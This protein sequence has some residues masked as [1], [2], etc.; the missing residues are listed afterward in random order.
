[1][2]KYRTLKGEAQRAREQGEKVT[3]DAELLLGLI[4]DYEHYYNESYRLVNV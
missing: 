3:L 1:M 2:F 4:E